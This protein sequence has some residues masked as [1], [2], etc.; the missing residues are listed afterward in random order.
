MLRKESLTAGQAQW[1]LTVVSSQMSSLGWMI[2]PQ[3]VGKRDLEVEPGRGQPFAAPA[4]S[5]GTAAE[6]LTE[7]SLLA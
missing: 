2:K 6:G 4:L 1:T 5:A 3:G 7:L